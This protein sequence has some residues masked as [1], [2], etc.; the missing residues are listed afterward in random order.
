MRVSDRMLLGGGIAVLGETRLH[1][2]CGYAALRY[3]TSDIPFY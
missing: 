3:V 1:F 2:G